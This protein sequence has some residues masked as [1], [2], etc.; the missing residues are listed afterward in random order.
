MNWIHNLR[1]VEGAQKALADFAASLRGPT[2]LKLVQ[3]I[4]AEGP[5][6]LLTKDSVKEASLRRCGVPDAFH[7]VLERHR[8]GSEN[9]P[10]GD[11]PYITLAELKS[12][13]TR[14]R[15]GAYPMSC[16]FVFVLLPMFVKRRETYDRKQF[17]VDFSRDLVSKE[18]LDKVWSIWEEH[19]RAG[20]FGMT[21]DAGEIRDQQAM[22]KFDELFTAAPHKAT[23]FEIVR[24]D[25]YMNGECHLHEVVLRTGLSREE[26]LAVLKECSHRGKDKS[27]RFF[28]YRPFLELI[29]FAPLGMR[30]VVYDQARHFTRGEAFTLSEMAFVI[31]A[32]EDS[33]LLGDAFRSLVKDN[34]FTVDKTCRPYRYS[35]AR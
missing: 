25:M 1:S 16:H 27:K 30:G 19:A 5:K 4:N 35:I 17:L 18:T 20:R 28:I 10:K 22:P 14:A 3:A 15:T 29:C 24:D 13:A 34:W 32:L 12:E 21:W 23:N 9:L 6:I 11:V 26:V 2:F 7:R 33:T 31:G 8:K